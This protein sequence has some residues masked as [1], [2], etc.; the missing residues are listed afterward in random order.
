NVQESI[1]AYCRNKSSISIRRIFMA[2]FQKVPAKNKQG[3]R[4]KCTQEA[5]RHPVSGKRRQVRRRGETK[6]QAEKREDKANEELIKVDKGE[7]NQDLKDITVKELFDKWFELVMKRRLKESTFR[8]YR[9]TS[10]IRILS[11]IGNHK[12]TKL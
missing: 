6:K 9:N 3:Y 12:V 4:W 11:V 8:E 5:P 1:N 2:Y 10:K 7:Y